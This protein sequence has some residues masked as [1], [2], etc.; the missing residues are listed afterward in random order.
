MRIEHFRNEAHKVAGRLES[1]STNIGKTIEV[2]RRLLHTDEVEVSSWNVREGM[3]FITF[4]SDVEIINVPEDE[5]YVQQVLRSIFPDCRI[6]DTFIE[7][8]SSRLL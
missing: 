7:I 2:L 1:M 8:E 4:A 3:I 6:I 5:R